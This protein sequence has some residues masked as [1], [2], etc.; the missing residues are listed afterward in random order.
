[1]PSPAS[2]YSTAIQ[3]G[4]KTAGVGLGALARHLSKEGQA[5]DRQ[6]EADI[7]ALKRNEFGPTRAQQEKLVGDAVSL[8]RQQAQ[9]QRAEAARQRA[10][11]GYIM[12]AQTG[13]DAK[14]AKAAADTAGTA[15]LAVSDAAAK[16]AAMAKREA[17][18]RVTGRAAKTEK[19]VAS[20]FGVA[21]SAAAQ[22]AGQDAAAARDLEFERNAAFLRDAYKPKQLAAGG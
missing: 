14:I 22:G 18:D 13:Q 3:T 8:A 21:E 7:D 1:M 12:G 5:E 20:I 10:A 15:R 4:A 17:L 19:D 9:A 2:L 16:Q 11:S 6:A